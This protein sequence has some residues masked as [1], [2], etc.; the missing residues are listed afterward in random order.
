MVI[1]GNTMVNPF[2]VTFVIEAP[3]A[4]CMN[5][6]SVASLVARVRLI[7]GG[8]ANGVGK[9]TFTACEYFG[10]V[11]VPAIFDGNLMSPVNSAEPAAENP[12]LKMTRLAN[13]TIFWNV[14]VRKNW[15]VS[16]N[17]V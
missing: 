8:A 10:T 17:K 7:T 12:F 5:A 3:T 11:T 1:Y 15:T 13:V 16:V 14:T 2:V 6:L 9:T 4:S